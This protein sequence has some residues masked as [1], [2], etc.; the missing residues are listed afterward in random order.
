MARWL[1]LAFLLVPVVEIAVIVQVGQLIGVWWTVAL[2]VLES[3]LGAWLVKREGRRAWDSLRATVGE[4]RM[5]DVQLLDAALVVVGGTLLLTPGFV[6]DVVGFACVL[7]VT[8]PAV[9]RV[10]GWL[11]LRRTER[12]RLV[13][14]RRVD[15]RTDGGDE[16]GGRDG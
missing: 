14:S 5:P 6:T 15:E 16:A 9:R 2:L 4:G 11:L 8:R 7:P 1:V 3:L 10:A 12:V 13:Q